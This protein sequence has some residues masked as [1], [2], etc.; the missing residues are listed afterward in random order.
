M[1]VHPISSSWIENTSKESKEHV[2]Q[3]FPWQI[4][5]YIQK[6]LLW[7]TLCWAKE[8]DVTFEVIS[9]FTSV[10]LFILLRTL[11]LGVLSFRII[12]ASQ[13]NKNLASPPPPVEENEG[14]IVVIFN[15]FF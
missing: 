8:E 6:I 12:N 15:G 13:D 2:K 14:K 4:F 9:F 3:L 10:Q 5:I 11:W 1:I 7:L